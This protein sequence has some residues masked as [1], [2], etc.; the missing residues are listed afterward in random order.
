VSLA[1]AG[2]VVASS[3]APVSASAEIKPLQFET[4]F[5]LD[6]T[7]ANLNLTVPAAAADTIHLDLGSAAAKWEQSIGAYLDGLLSADEAAA[8]TTAAEAAAADPTPEASLDEATVVAEDI[9]AFQPTQAAAKA[10]A[11]GNDEP[12]VKDEPSVNA[13]AV[14]NANPLLLAPI[15]SHP[16]DCAGCRAHAE[17]SAAAAAPT[18][19]P[20]DDADAWQKLAEWASA[21]LA[22]DR[23]AGDAD[24]SD[25][26][27]AFDVVTA[28]SVFF[29]NADDDSATE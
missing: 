6:L 7:P 27:E 10:E 11:A 18:V 14:A 21:R 24:D 2:V 23:S 4:E 5:D 9:K 13:D 16:M 3:L 19:T 8:A 22:E 26:F 25:G 17:P 29:E 28:E 15:L 1:A 12:S 20:V